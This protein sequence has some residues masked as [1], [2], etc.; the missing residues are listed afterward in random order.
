MAQHFVPAHQ[1]ELHTQYHVRYTHHVSLVNTIDT[2]YGHECLLCIITI[3]NSLM[4]KENV[5]NAFMHCT[6][7][8]V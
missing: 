8:D 6:V 3:I 7:H 4:I 2:R 1:I 5:L